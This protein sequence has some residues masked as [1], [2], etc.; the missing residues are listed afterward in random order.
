MGTESKK[1]KKDS[2][3]HLYRWL[4]DDVQLLEASDENPNTEVV[5]AFKDI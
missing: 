2:G 4:A 1:R 3:G 5:R